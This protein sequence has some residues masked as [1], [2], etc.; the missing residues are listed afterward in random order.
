MKITFRGYQHRLIYLAPQPV[1]L[2]TQ[3]IHRPHNSKILILIRV[4][5]TDD[6]QKWVGLS[7]FTTGHAPPTGRYMY[8]GTLRLRIC[9]GP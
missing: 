4:G 5:D 9:I 8:E 6:M 7:P 2:S 3:V 1:S